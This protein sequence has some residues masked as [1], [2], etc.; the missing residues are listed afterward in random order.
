MND[1]RNRFWVTAIGRSGTHKIASILSELSGTQ[2]RHE[3]ADPRDPGVA[4]PFSRFPIDR[5]WGP[6]RVYGECHGMLRYHLSCN[7]PGFER[8]IPRRA[9]IYRDLRKVIAA[10]MNR[11][12]RKIEELSAVIYEISWQWF[13]L[14]LYADSDPGCPIWNFDRLMSDLP[15]LKAFVLHMGFSAEK[16]TADLQVE[17]ENPTPPSDR[18]FSWSDDTE[19][20]FERINARIWNPAGVRSNHIE[21]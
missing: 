18:W 15:Y 7:V 9:I 20:L 5:F 1:L 3:D 11:D 6:E 8:Q 19:A 17:V 10:W 12:D 21:K 13:N 2:V 14:E 16:V 4:W